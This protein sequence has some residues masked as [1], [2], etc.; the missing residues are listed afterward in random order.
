MDLGVEVSRFLLIS[1]LPVD[2]FDRPNIR[3]TNK[4]GEG[5]AYIAGGKNYFD[6]IAIGLLIV[7]TDAAHVHPPTGAQGLNSGA[8]DAVSPPPH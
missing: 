8:Q 6:L 4:F 7:G 3:M 1:I 2:E 5:R